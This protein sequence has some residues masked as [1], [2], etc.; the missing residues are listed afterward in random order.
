MADTHGRHRGAHPGRVRGGGWSCRHHYPD[1]QALLRYTGPCRG[2]WKA[3]AGTAQAGEGGA[4]LLPGAGR[5]PGEG[6]PEHVHP[7]GGRGADPAGAGGLPR[8]G[9]GGA[10]AARGPLDD[11]R[12]RRVRALCRGRSSVQAQGHPAGRERGNLHSKHKDWQ[13][14]RRVRADLHD[15]PRRGNVGQGAAPWSGGAPDRAS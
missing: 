3:A 8:R 5:A 1:Q 12:P 15:E 6:H 7:R 4:V 13:G 11:P 10:E 9:S 14:P 2:E